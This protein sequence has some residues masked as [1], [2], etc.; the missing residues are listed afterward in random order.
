LLEPLDSSSIKVLFDPENKKQLTEVALAVMAEAVSRGV[1][2][3]VKS[4][5]KMSFRDLIRQALSINPATIEVPSDVSDI[6]YV[7]STTLHR[8]LPS[9]QTNYLL[10]MIVINSGK[11]PPVQSGDYNVESGK[12]FSSR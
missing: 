2:V 9:P 7:C 11:K 6:M 3:L 10:C 1:R 5:E 12:K 4:N 8:L